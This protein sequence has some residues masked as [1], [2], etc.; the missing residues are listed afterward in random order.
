MDDW[1]KNHDQ[2]QTTYNTERP[3]VS[4]DEAS[5]HKTNEIYTMLATPLKNMRA[6]AM[7]DAAKNCFKD[8][9]MDEAVPN[10]HQ[11]EMCIERMQNRHMGV[12]YRNLVELR[13]STRYQYQDCIV[14]A[15]N[16]VEKAV[17]CVRNYLTG[18]DADNQ[19]LKGIVE[20]DCAKYF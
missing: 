1:K 11:V 12:F 14:D 19:K 10:P 13:E 8:K 9:W 7:K 3:G 2:V 20:R 5:F 6:A 18:I 15:G 16:N 17:F 4:P